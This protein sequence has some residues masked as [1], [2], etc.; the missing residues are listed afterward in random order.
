MTEA[1]PNLNDWAGGKAALHRL[2]TLF[3]QKVAHDP[4][5]GPVFATMDPHHAEH[6]AAFI[7]EVLGGKPDYSATGGNHADMIRKHM[8]R[9]LTEAM[10]RRW[11]TLLMDA[12][13]DIGLPDDPEFRASFSGYLEWGSRLAVMNSQDGVADPDSDLPMPVWA[14]SSPGGPYQG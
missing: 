2:T 13:E 9:H 12:A 4:L 10:R 5:I 3:Y 14:W 7:S 1:I 6:V 11:L 8:G